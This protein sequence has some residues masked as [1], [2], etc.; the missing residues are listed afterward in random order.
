MGFRNDGTI[1]SKMNS[2]RWDDADDCG[3]VE[4]GLVLDSDI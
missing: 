2:E 3:I 1:L 4:S